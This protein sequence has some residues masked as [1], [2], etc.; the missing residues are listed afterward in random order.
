MA[1]IS[2]KMA[3]GPYDRTEPLRD[4]NGVRPEGI[5]LT[6]DSYQSP[7]DIFMMMV[8][9]DD[10]HLGE[11]SCS[12]FMSQSSQEAVP[13]VAL[14]VFPSRVFRHSF[15]F[16]NKNAGIKTAAD[17]KNK[18]IGVPVFS[19]TAAVWIRGFL[20]EDFGVRT[21]DVQWFEGGLNLPRK[22]HVLDGVHPVGMDVT[23][24]AILD[25]STLSDE[26]EK[27][28][29]DAIIGA[30]IPDSFYQGENVV[31]LFPN[32]HE[33]EKDYFQRTGIYPIMHTVAMRR[34][35]YSE[36]PWIAESMYN[37]LAAAKQQV[38]GQQLHYRGAQKTMLPWQLEAVEEMD[39]LF[40]DGDP[41]PYGLERNRSTLDAL[42]RHLL[43]QGLM[44]KHMA[45]DDLFLPFNA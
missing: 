2:I 12:Y 7:Q 36:Q 6:Y 29:L 9:Q 18:R 33:V 30:D 42:Q 5:D 28:E 31:R 24:G 23:V 21:E 38:L 45:L 10:Y 34:Q 37:A 22:P 41:W 19:M 17:L 40:P 32:Y 25:A 20:Q 14:P 27:G 1:N 15:I 26:L 44:V 13:L 11:L 8:A 43:D 3:C 16:I 39:A 4:K 35:L